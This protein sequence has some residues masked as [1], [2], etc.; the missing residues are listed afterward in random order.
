MEEM[1]ASPVFE[2]LAPM[3]M[4]DNDEQAMKDASTGTIL[5]ETTKDC[6]ELAHHKQLFFFCHDLLCLRCPHE[7]MNLEKTYQTELE[8]Q[9]PDDELPAQMQCEKELEL[10]TKLE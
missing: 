10:E 1:T 8:E 6:L 4:L 5:A 7:T 9:L 2:K 3:T